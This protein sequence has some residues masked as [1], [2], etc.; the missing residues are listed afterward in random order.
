MICRSVTTIGLVAAFIG[1]VSTGT[2]GLVHGSDS[3]ITIETG[4]R[5]LFVDDHIVG[6]IVHLRRTLHQPL[7]MGAVIRP[8][9]L[10]N[11]PSV[12]TR[13]APVWD[14]QSELY[15]FATSAGLYV[16][17]D[18]LH[19]RLLV[20]DRDT[21]PNHM[22]YDRHETDPARR[23]KGL[24]MV[25]L[26][27]VKEVLDERGRVRP[28]KR[29]AWEL[30][31]RVSPDGLAWTELDVPG[32]P[33][34]DE[35]NLSYDEK[36]RLFIVTVKV[37]GRY[38]RSH[39]LSTSRDFER[40]TKPELT[41]EADE[42]DQYLDREKIQM[43]MAD[44][45]DP[46]LA[47]TSFG[48]PAAY[49]VDV[50]NL[51]IFRYE[52][53]Y[54]GLPAIHPS[55][56]LQLDDLSNNV[57]YKYLQLLSSR[58]LKSWGRVGDRRSFMA[59]SPKASDA[60]DRSA[61]M[62]ASWPIVRGDELWFYYS[63]Y[64]YAGWPPTS[65][66]HKYWRLKEKVAPDAEFE[67]APNDLDRAA[68]CL[69]VLRRDGFVSL[70]ADA[71]GGTIVTKPLRTDGTKLMINARLAASGELRAAL[72][73]ES[74]LPLEGR[75][76]LEKCG[77]VKGDQPAAEMKW[78]GDELRTLQASPF[79]IRFWLRD[80]EF[81]SFWFADGESGAVG[82]TRKEAASAERKPTVT[83]RAAEALGQTGML[84]NG[85][86]HPYGAPTS[87]YFEYGPTESYG[88]RT[89]TLALP[90]RLTAYY[91][92]TWDTDASGWGGGGFAPPEGD[93]K[94]G[95]FRFTEPSGHDFN[96]IDGVGTLHLCKYFYPG[97]AATVFKRLGAFLGG[98]HPD[99]RGARVSMAVRGN[100]WKPNGTTLLWWTQSQS[101]IELK[102][103]L[104]WKRANWAYTGFTLNNVLRSG[105][106]EKVDYRLHEDSHSWSYGG[107]NLAQKYPERYSY[108]PI[109]QA[110]RDLN[111]DF[112]HL[113]MGV[114]PQNPPE[115]SI[116]F[117]DFLLTYRNYS[118]LSPTNGGRLLS[119]PPADT[120]VSWLRAAATLTDGWRHG[121]NKMW[122]SAADPSSPQ[123]FVYELNV[124]MRSPAAVTLQTI[125]LHQNPEW[126]ARDVEVLVSTDGESFASLL[127]TR[128][129]EH[130]VP[131]AN[132]AFTI[133]RDLSTTARFLKVRVLS[134][135]RK[136]HWGM[137]EIEAFGSGA[138]MATEHEP[139]RVTADVTELRPGTT[140]HYRLVALSAA[141]SSY[142]ENRTFR[143]ASNG[144]PEAKTSSASEI[145]PT[146]ARLAGRFNPLG[147]KSEYYFEYGTDD[148]YGS[149]TPILY[150]GRQIT[151]RAAFVKLEN[152]QPNSEYHYRV[153]VK[154]W[155]GTTYGQD[156]AF[157]T[158][159][160]TAPDWVKVTDE[161]AWQARD[162]QG[163][164]VYKN[165]LW[166]F[167]GWFNSYEAPPRDVWS[168]ADGVH[169]ELV[170]ERAPWKHSDFSMALVFKDKMW[171]MGGWYNGR[172]PGHSASNK[173]W[174]SED[175][176]EWTLA[177]DNAGW[178][179]R[180]AAAA[181]VFQGKMWIL[182]GTENYY[183]G[184]DASLKNDVWYSAD[185]KTWSL[186]TESAEWSPRAYHQAVVLNDKIYVF[187]G[188]NY[189]PAYDAKNDVWCS[190]DGVQ[191]TQLTDAAPW[192]PRLWFSSVVYRDRMWVLG[193][194]GNY[195]WRNFGDVWY[196]K[197]GVEWMELKSNVVW[198][199]RHEHSAFVF[200]DTVWV[201]GG[202]AQPLSREVW[203]LKVPAGWF[204]GE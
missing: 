163:E 92:E 192:L 119:A 11:V 134:G 185:G 142:G 75:F 96:H 58:D 101:N 202:H 83:T 147:R 43:R 59:P 173:V 36:N 194:W 85:T 14:P 162:S 55:M 40:W 115:G 62:P 133:A 84:V 122:K 98:G 186:A 73:D 57:A 10:R 94:S 81:Y 23:F 33:C 82:A 135:Y 32:I 108:W 123:E 200:N 97:T 155:A 178:T 193:G 64:K 103:E 203:S 111:I 45:D 72:L 181:V 69:A 34:K 196:S 39:A 4:E 91:H 189:V 176:K 120:D 197:D 166:M 188:G 175:G 109:T 139:Y 78:Q 16:S 104:G 204:A 31:P 151:P 3:A 63:G 132:F 174:S 56:A 187:G 60:Y 150:G 198:K 71:A 66:D 51:S 24:K 167:G 145:S 113:V 190:D 121:R 110:Q 125:Q 18:G 99:L 70:D 165:R 65:L 126:P 153:V 148:R 156:V 191:W 138:L 201:A 169:W 47:I 160:A 2:V 143:A 182:G 41:F 89:E 170:E 152:L 87:Y 199:A 180:I 1:V 5:Q 6:E 195:P 130:S 149:K 54:L 53:V 86:I 118:L 13:S 117:D 129:E 44:R 131:N 49:K 95:F 158:P 90:P 168:S 88:Q 179:P 27:D 30:R 29:L 19:W 137:G 17:S 61:V 25:A 105:E 106:W 26:F 76:T 141:G 154:N 112:F 52:S 136:K 68:I 67:A 12:Y 74:G 172:L 107:N 35:T 114:D 77:R 140:Y 127:K 102:M 15:K 159:S 79:R 144:K 22:I 177:K 93:A 21:V 42:F 48:D 80:G 8:D 100:Q 184:D 9:F 46:R 50:Y 37:R 161:A 38:G 128:M 116:D 124:G 28:G 146:G 164:L 183:F 157:Q 7:K 20:T 171:F